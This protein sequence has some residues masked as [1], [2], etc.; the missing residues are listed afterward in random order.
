[1]DAAD[2]EKLKRPQLQQLCKK[3]GLRAAG[4]V[5]FCGFDYA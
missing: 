2:I 5:R 1:M 4:K 3:F